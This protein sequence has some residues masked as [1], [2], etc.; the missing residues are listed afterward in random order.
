MKTRDLW[1]VLALLTPLACDVDRPV[2]DGDP[3]PVQ[4]EV[5][6][7]EDP[8]AEEPASLACEVL[9]QARAC[10]LPDGSEGTAFCG[11]AATEDNDVIA[12]ADELAWGSCYAEVACELGA[13]EHCGFCPEIPDEFGDTPPAQA[14]GDCPGFTKTCQIVGDAPG[15]DEWA[16]SWDTPLVLSFDGGPIRMEAAGAASFDIS[17]VG[18]CQSTDWPAAATPWL[19]LDLDRSGS[20]DSGRELFG[21]GTRLSSGERATGGFDALADLDDNRDGRI[22]AADARFGELVLWA[23]HDA[24]KAS[25]FAEVTP[26]AARGI[27]S[28]DL[29][30]AHRPTCDERGNCAVERSSFT[31]VGAGGAVQRGEVADLHLACQ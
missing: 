4:G 1:L 28:I 14:P 15:Y 31:Y 22:D 21:S 12:D 29:G 10:E 27:L 8:P 19:A 16:C 17:G 25:T 26:L 13:E 7:H 20:I 2:D 11:Y 18:T 3:G 30:Y 9:G 6:D 24:D 23:D 5:D